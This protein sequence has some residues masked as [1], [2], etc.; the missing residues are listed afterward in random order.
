MLAIF[1][2]IGA[3]WFYKFRFTCEEYGRA[4]V[5]RLCF[6]YWVPII[7]SGIIHFADPDKKWTIWML[8]IFLGIVVWNAVIIVLFK[9]IMSR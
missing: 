1:H 4:W 6:C 5:Q 3:G 7:L 9:C 2:C 8:P